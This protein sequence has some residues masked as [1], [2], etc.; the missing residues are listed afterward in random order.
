MSV[1]S[2]AELEADVLRVLWDAPCTAAEVAVV[3]GTSDH[4]ARVALGLLAVRGAVV[5]CGVV[6]GEP[7]ALRR[8]PVHAVWR[9]AAGP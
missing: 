2:V 6:R 3:L 5:T 9:C 8:R 7:D 4:L 1:L